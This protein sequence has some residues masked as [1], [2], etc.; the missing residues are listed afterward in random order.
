MAAHEFKPGFRINLHR[1][2]LGIIADTGK[3]Y[4]VPL[5]VTSVVSQLF[6]SVASAGHGDLDHSAVL[7]AIEDLA[8]HRVGEPS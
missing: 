6:E 8:H 2:D 1:K 3:T 5:P 7:T 4:N